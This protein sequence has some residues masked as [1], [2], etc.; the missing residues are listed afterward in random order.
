MILCPSHF[1]KWEGEVVP[2]SLLND[3]PDPEVTLYGSGYTP[4]RKIHPIPRFSV[5]TLLMFVARFARVSFYI[6]LYI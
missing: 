5:A 6:I 1:K 4:P 2:V 3:A